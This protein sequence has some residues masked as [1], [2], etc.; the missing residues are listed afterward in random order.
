MNTLIRPALAG[1]LALFG[2]CCQAADS[3]TLRISTLA[4]QAGAFVKSVDGTGSAAEFYLPRGVAIDAA[5]NVYVADSANHTIRKVTPAGVVTT[6]AGVPG[7]TGTASATPARFNEPFGVAVDSA[8][9]AY[10]ADTNNNAIRKVS[11]AGVVTTLAGGNGMGSA[12]GTGAAARFAEPR[13]IALDSSGN[14]YVADYENDTIRKVTPAGVVTTLAGA[15]NTPGFADGTGSA[16]RFRSVNGI[17]VDGAGNLYV[18]D[19]GNRAI[20]KV[21][22]AGVVTTLVDGSNG[23]LGEPRGVAVAADGTVYVAD[24]GAHVI[25]RISPAGV[26]TRLAGTAPT[27]GS[28]DGASALFNRPSGIVIDGANGLVVADTTNCT[29]RRVTLAGAVTTLAGLAGRSASVDGVGAAAR[30][31]DPYAVATDG[32]RVYVADATDHTIRRIDADG[33][34]TTLAGKAAAFGTNDGTRTD[35]RFNGPMGIAADSSGNVYVADSGNR[36]IRKVTP[37]GVVTTLAGT[38]GVRGSR[39]GT[40]PAALFANPTGVAVDGSGN[41]YVVDFESATLR[42]ITP[43]GVVTTLAGSAGA[44]GFVDGIGS[45]S[46]FSL[47]ID[48]TVDTAGMIY[49]VDRNN[50]AIRKVTPAGVVTTLAGS[51]SAGY[52]NGSGTVATFK[53]PSGLAVDGA[54]NVYVADTDNQVI[55]RVTPSGEVSTVAG[56]GLGSVD[57]PGTAAAFYDPKDVAAD[58]TGRIYVTDRGNHTVRKGTPIATHFAAASPYS[59]L[60]WNPAES[61]WGM[62][63]TQHQGILFTAMY[64]YDRSAQPTWLV[65]SRCPMVTTGSCSGEIFR[66]TGGTHPG[67]AWNGAARVV[68]PVGS[69]TLTF[70]DPDHGRLTFTIDGVA[71]SKSIERQRFSNGTTAPSV[72]FTDLWW[73]AA[74]SGWGV[75]LTQD[76]G[77]IFATWFAYDT[78][79]NPVWY[80]ASSCPLVANACAGDLYRVAGGSALTSPWTSSP[81]AVKAGTVSFTF[82]DDSTGVMAWTLDGVA[83]TRAIVRQAF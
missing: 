49:V 75:A 54:G 14:V 52:A 42:K 57:A 78:G 9:T 11:P 8:G 19:A 60:W 68:A 24:H 38:A 27:P 18:A 10:V 23:Q 16:A 50:H 1:A 63:V 44:N 53:F 13:G 81:A 74:E 6:L 30:F 34:T 55:R 7:S 15:V 69:G 26:V 45:A 32:T 70:S 46:R 71:G 80:V 61:G 31:E 2:A 43:A 79:G 51:G 48:V 59:G 66:V 77:M 64:T 83:G 17:A 22:P 5:G 28:S 65:M 62:S 82:S 25:H 37:D 73:N 20:R 29:I 58:A 72:D 56:S 40:G 47:P 36:T 33:T 41:V 67:I 3:T 21:S 4:G 35:A 39:D 76:A 12:D